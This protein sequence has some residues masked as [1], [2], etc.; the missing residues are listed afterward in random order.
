MSRESVFVALLLAFPIVSSALLS[1][2]RPV[3]PDWPSSAAAAVP[4]IAGNGTS[5]VLTTGE[6]R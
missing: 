4:K 1:E 5:F 6:P 2:R 3:S